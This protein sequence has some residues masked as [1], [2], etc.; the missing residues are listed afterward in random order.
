MEYEAN[1]IF[2][3]QEYPAKLIFN[4]KRANKLKKQIDHNVE[5]YKQWSYKQ[6]IIQRVLA[7]TF[8]LGCIIALAV[9][10]MSFDVATICFGIT[11]IGM[12]FWT[13]WD[14]YIF[15]QEPD[16]TYPNSVEF[17]LIVRS[18][19]IVSIAI[20]RKKHS[21]NNVRIIAEN[22]A[23]VQTTYYLTFD[24]KPAKYLRYII[25]DIDAGCIR[26]PYI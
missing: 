19:D 21:K 7:G 23:H 4:S 2:N 8:V 20:S 9:T 25:M 17:F 1:V 18:K 10:N 13:I 14:R 22:D 6:L 5:A 26:V 16:A 11:C 15:E 12:I 3:K 24:I